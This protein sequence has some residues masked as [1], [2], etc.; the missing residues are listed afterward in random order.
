MAVLWV[1]ELPSML[2][3]TRARE[4]ARRV[5]CVNNMKGIGLACQL[6]AADRG[7]AFPDSFGRV[8][9]DYVSSP[10]SFVCP[11][12]GAVVGDPAALGIWTDYVLV[13]GRSKSD[14]PGA[15]L[16]YCRPGNH[17]DEGTV[18]LFVDGRVEW[19][20]GG[21][22]VDLLRNLPAAHGPER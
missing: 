15:V 6:Y 19:L 4:K 18:V 3:A 16:A 11:K 10:R 21:E 5:A 22:L 1:P 9:P 12:T 8:Y 20:A 17:G 13:P 2:G 14:D 7:E